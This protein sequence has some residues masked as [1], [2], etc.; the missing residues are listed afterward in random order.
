M[1][2]LVVAMAQTQTDVGSRRLHQSEEGEVLRAALVQRFA[3][4]LGWRFESERVVIT[5]QS[6][7]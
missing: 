5:L 3:G 2:E 7:K 1:T 4:G 6:G